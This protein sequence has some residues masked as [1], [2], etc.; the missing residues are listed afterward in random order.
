ML[1]DS[2]SVQ[3]TAII[4]SFA[5][6]FLL[7]SHGRRILSVAR[8]ITSPQDTKLVLVVRTDLRMSVG[9]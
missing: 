2:N 7:K 4:A 6:G 5:A 1:L 8:Q 9:E 3:V